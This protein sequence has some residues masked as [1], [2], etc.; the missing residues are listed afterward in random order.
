VG[1]LQPLLRALQSYSRKV[2]FKKCAKEE[3]ILK[4]GKS[5]ISKFGRSGSGDHFSG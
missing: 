1:G 4:V 3:S 5:G 2:G